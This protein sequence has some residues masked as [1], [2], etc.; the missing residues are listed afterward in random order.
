[1]SAHDDWYYGKMGEFVDP[2][3][4]PTSDTDLEALQVCQVEGVGHAFE[5]GFAGV[6][7]PDRVRLVGRCMRCGAGYLSAPH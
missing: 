6:L 4:L 1:M 2:S 3:A 5:G 7:G